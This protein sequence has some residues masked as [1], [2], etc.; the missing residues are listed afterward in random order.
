MRFSG[1][2]AERA[3][4][5]EGGEGEQWSSRWA[6]RRSSRRRRGHSVDLDARDKVARERV[7]WL[8]KGC[9]WKW[10]RDRR[11]GLEGLEAGRNFGNVCIY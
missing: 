11:T 9:G 3:T 8:R 10:W 1:G 2:D 7:Y 6:G 5:E 4:S